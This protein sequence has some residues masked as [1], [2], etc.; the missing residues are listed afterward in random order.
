MHTAVDDRRAPGFIRMIAQPLG[1]E[2][3]RTKPANTFDFC[4]IEPTEH[5]QFI[6]RYAQQR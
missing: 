5:P 2:A 6:I 1:R 3:A 4:G